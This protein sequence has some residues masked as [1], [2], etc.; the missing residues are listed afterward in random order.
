MKKIILTSILIVFCLNIFSQY[1]ISAIFS[2]Q[3]KGIGPMC[4][5]RIHKSIISGGVT[6][7]NYN[8]YITQHLE[9][10]LSY[11]YFTTR[12]QDA[13]LLAD[14][15]YNKFNIS[16]QLPFFFNNKAFTKVTFSLGAGIILGHYHSSFEYDFIQRVGAITV[17]Y[18]FIDRSA[19]SRSVGY[20]SHKK[21]FR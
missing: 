16:D 19:K 20:R 11:G 9:T 5:Y 18:Y 6:Y 3:D 13:Y 21:R 12:S 17:G 1:S 7:G 14:V 2:P 4:S 8:E 15:H 10:Y